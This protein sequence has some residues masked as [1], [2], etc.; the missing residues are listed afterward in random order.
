MEIDEQAKSYNEI[1]DIRQV[2]DY[3]TKEGLGAE[4]MWMALQSYK[5]G[6]SLNDAL[7]HGLREWDL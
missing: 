5:Q 3:A 4:V 6:Y 2:L 7:T 1:E